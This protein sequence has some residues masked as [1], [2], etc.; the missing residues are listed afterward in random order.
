MKFDIHGRRGPMVA[1]R[2]F[3]GKEYRFDLPHETE[4]ETE[5]RILDGDSLVVGTPSKQPEPAQDPI[6]K[7]SRKEV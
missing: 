7:S 1:V 2:Y 5:I 6:E 3:D 4:D